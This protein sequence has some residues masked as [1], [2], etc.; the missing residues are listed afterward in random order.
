[1]N[2]PM[3]YTHNNKAAAWSPAAHLNEGAENDSWVTSYMDILTLMLTL[4]VLLVAYQMHSKSSQET[5][6]ETQSAQEPA[7]AAQT[8]A[9]APMTEPQQPSVKHTE[10]DD[11]V[12]QVS[13]TATPQPAIE[14]TETTPVPAN[15]PSA[16]TNPLA[17]ASAAPAIDV[18]GLEAALRS[19]LS[20]S[21]PPVEILPDGFAVALSEQILFAP[22]S[23]AISG[24]G[25]DVLRNI[26]PALAEF[27]GEVFIEGHT[28]NS[29]ITT[30]L[31]PSNWE[32]STH[33]A[34]SVTRLLIEFGLSPTRMRAVGFGDTHPLADNQTPQG[35]AANR[36]VSL[37]VKLPAEKA[38]SAELPAT[39]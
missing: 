25:Q 11:L 2:M 38:A 16:E 24:Q 4:F 3:N 39:L 13:L 37:I 18:S 5:Q 1:M 17:E 20:E 29:P 19:A 32:L 22:G 28:D 36:R 14:L 27:S 21:I 10:H 31:F 23:T 7:T 30:T 12:A 35:R 9:V 26:A 33:R 6:Q 34:T 15:P 8:A